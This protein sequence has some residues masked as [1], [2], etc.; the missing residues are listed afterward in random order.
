MIGPDIRENDKEELEAAPESHINNNNKFSAEEMKDPANRR[1]FTL[2]I[3]NQYYV[4][5]TRGIDGIRVGFW[6][7]D[8]FRQYIE[9]TLEID[10]GNTPQS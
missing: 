3:L 5:L 1:E 4:L 6:G 9:K 7:N 8:E 2:Y 10:N